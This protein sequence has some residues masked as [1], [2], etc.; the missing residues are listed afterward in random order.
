MPSVQSQRS[1]TSDR[2]PADQCTHEGDTQAT[3][4]YAERP[5][6]SQ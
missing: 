6:E 4:S 3:M 1:V 5:R 2:E